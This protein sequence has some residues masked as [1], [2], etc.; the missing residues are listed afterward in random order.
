MCY[1]VLDDD[2]KLDR[3]VK[4]YKV[5]RCCHQKEHEVQNNLQSVTSVLRLRRKKLVSTDEVQF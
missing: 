4:V 1:S 3:I 2:G 5:S